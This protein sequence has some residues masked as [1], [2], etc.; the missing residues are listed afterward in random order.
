MCGNGRSGACKPDSAPGYVQENILVDDC[1][2][3]VLSDLGSVQQQVYMGLPAKKPHTCTISYCPPENFKG[4]PS[5]PCCAPHRC[6]EHSQ[7][8]DFPDVDHGRCTAEK[9]S[10]EANAR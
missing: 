7:A 2:N 8:Q 9:P 1:G 6:S 10:A 4:K 5:W 3:W